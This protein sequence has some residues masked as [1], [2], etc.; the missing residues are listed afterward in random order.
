[1]STKKGVMSVERATLLAWNDTCE[2]CRI[3]GTKEV[4]H[5]NT[6]VSRVRAYVNGREGSYY[7]LDGNITRRLREL[8]EQ[9][10][11]NYEYKDDVYYNV[12]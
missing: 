2:Q 10:I 9:G 8:R 4:V 11:I 12:P 6:F 1:M 7:P 5:M 3:N